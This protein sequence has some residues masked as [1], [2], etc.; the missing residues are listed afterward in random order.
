[1]CLKM[2]VSFCHL[3]YNKYTNSSLW[4]SP[5]HVDLISQIDWKRLNQ[6]Q[7]C[8]F[9]WGFSRRKGEI[10]NEILINIKNQLPKNKISQANEEACREAHG[11]QS[12][13]Q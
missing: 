3:L 11:K 4:L 10:A 2:L 5:L 8:T 7:H 6:M 13:L 9:W 12:H 1:M